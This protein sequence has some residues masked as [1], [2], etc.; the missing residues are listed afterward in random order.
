MAVPGKVSM[1]RFGFVAA[2][3][4]AAL[5]AAPPGNAA[6]QALIDAAKREGSVTWYTTLLV[7]EASGPLA[8]AFEKK[9]PGIHVDVIRKDGSE[10]LRNIMAEAKA[11]QMKADVFDGTTTAAFLM[12]EGI[13]APYVADSAKDIPARYKDARGY[14]TAQVLYFQ[15]LGYNADLV[16]ER[17]SPKTYQDL[18]NPKWKGKLAWSVEEQLTGGLGFIVNVLD[19]MGDAKGTE[20]LGALAN[21]DI[22]RIRTGINGVTR[23]LAAKQYAIGVAIDNHHTVIA[24][25]KGGNVRWV[26]IAPVLGLSNNIGLIRNA[27]HPNA[28]KLLIDFNLSED[29]Q[30]VLKNGNHIPAS[31]RIE[32]ADPSLKRG[33]A[34]N[35]ISPEKGVENTEKGLAVYKRVF[36]NP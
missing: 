21:Q 29:G 7:D 20:Y 11:G 28:A 22:A 24:N 2:L 13:A 10:H 3:A 5:L 32:A 25:E 19:T 17:D 8:A 33:F 6:S 30:T 1:T 26:A 34:V 16:P 31:E 9:Y 36:G 35:Y 12:K 4:A 18:L 14:W 23:A 27:P 15:T